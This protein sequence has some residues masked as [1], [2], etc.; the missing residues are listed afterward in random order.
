MIKKVITSV[1]L[2]F[3]IFTLISCNKKNN[4]AQTQQVL[5]ESKLEAEVPVVEETKSL[6]VDEYK[7]IA[8]SLGEKGGIALYGTGYFCDVPKSFTVESH[9]VFGLSGEYWPPEKPVTKISIAPSDQGNIVEWDL[10][11]VRIPESVYNTNPDVYL[12][13]EHDGEIF[14]HE[15]KEKLNLRVEKNFNDEI[16]DYY[17]TVIFTNK[18][19]YSKNNN[20]TV[21]LRDCNTNEQL[22]E[23]VIKQV[24][25]TCGYVAYKNDYKSPFEPS[26]HRAIQTNEKMHLIY[27]GKADAGDMIVISYG[28]YCDEGI[29]YV[30][31]TAIKANFEK[32]GIS[33]LDFTIRASGQY[34]IDF[35]NEKT[36]KKTE[37]SIFDYL[38]VSKSE[39]YLATEEEGRDWK[40]DSP[41][42]LRLRSAPWGER[43]YLLEDG[44]ELK[45]RYIFSY[46]FYDCIDNVPGF[47]IPVQIENPKEEIDNSKWVLKDDTV[48]NGWV[49]SGFL[50]NAD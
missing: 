14:Y 33:S 34:K 20:F 17:T 28:F 6:T 18:N 24:P 39:D 8:E 49:F 32:D 2:I 11:E 27:R 50:K 3:S 25:L 45:Q 44:Q 48:T 1:I 7:K 46:P 36:G 15:N 19:L 22:Y 31:F 9:R 26:E 47:W 12:E 10:L 23:T 30:P 16:I 43:L 29:A 40:V 41:E 35:Y 5:G 37:T 13:A 38:S 4:E 42:G 21:S